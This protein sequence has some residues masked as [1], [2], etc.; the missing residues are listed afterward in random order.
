M[1]AKGK[2]G[3][4][5]WDLD[6]TLISWQRRHGSLH[7][8]AVV[9]L[10]GESA[11]SPESTAGLTDFE[12][13]L[14][15]IPPTSEVSP[16]LVNDLLSELDRLFG[17]SL[18][19]DTISAL[20]GAA[21]TLAATQSCGWIN[22]V[23]TG[24]T[25]ARAISKC[26]A[27]GLLPQFEMA[28]SVFGNEHISRAALAIRARHVVEEALGEGTALAVVG[29]TARDMEAGMAARA[30]RVGALDGGSDRFTL[31]AAGAQHLL[32]M[33][34]NGISAFVEFLGSLGIPSP[35]P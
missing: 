5:L 16:A 11:S 24:N 4:L 23:L 20:P 8:Q 29:D 13:L 35:D 27:A 22:A 12:L 28:L 32:T 26:Q 15:L 2:A 6:G 30:Y 19:V 7:E 1:T 17:R 25:P 14:K 10:L 31:K 3:V 9:S 34:P 21:A 33:T 18:R